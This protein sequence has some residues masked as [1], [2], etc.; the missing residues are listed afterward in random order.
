MPN[1]PKFHCMG[2]LPDMLY[3][4]LHMRQECREHFPRH[5]L[6]RKP[7][8]SNPGM[9]H[10]TCV[11]HMPWCMLG[12]LPRGGGKKGSRHTWHIRNP[13]FYVLGMKPM[14]LCMLNSLWKHK[15]S[16][17]DHQIW[18]AVSWCSQLTG[19]TLHIVV[20]LSTLWL[21]MV[22][23]KAEASRTFLYIT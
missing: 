13:Q 7:L 16:T 17:E 1:P 6:Q 22:H 23:N 21:L 19:E 14:C 15:N 10:G 3:Y 8:V 9:H 4:V 5:R 12:S 20:T 2:L 18:E 11:T